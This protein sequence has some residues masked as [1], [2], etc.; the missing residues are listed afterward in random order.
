[1]NQQ[2]KIGLIKGLAWGAFSIL[3]IVII[4]FLQRR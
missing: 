4:Y 3:I 1:M 2:V